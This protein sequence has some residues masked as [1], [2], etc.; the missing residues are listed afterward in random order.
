MAKKY[1][2]PECR[3]DYETNESNPICPKCSAKEKKKIY[4]KEK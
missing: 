4:L 1:V 3:D 2:C